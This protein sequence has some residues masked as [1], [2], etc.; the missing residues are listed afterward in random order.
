ME[1]KK[2]LE[3]IIK[4]YVPVTR[5]VSGF[6]NSIE[7]LLRHRAGYRVDKRGGV[8]EYIYDKSGGAEDNQG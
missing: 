3:N 1:F 4:G 2:E 5:A 7:V 8:K 6:F